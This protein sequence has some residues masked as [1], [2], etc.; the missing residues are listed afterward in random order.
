MKK[1]EFIFG[2]NPVLEVLRSKK[3]KCH[4]IFISDS[5]KQNA[6][7]E[8]YNLSKSFGVKISNVDKQKIS[9]IAHDPKHQGVAARVDGYPF[10]SVQEILG[11]PSEGQGN[12]IIILDGI[13]DPHNLGAIIRTAH[14]LGADGII[15]P[16]D[17]ACDITATVVKSSAGAT[18]YLKIAQVVNLAREID[19]LKDSGLWVGGA[20]GEGAD[21]L[22]S[23]DFTNE[24]TV[25]VIGSEG[26]GLRQLIRK[27]CDFL[28]KIPMKGSIDSFNASVAAAL[29]MGEV[30][31]Q[32]RK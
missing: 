31:R 16:K 32:R 24:N 15:I 13:S 26:T 6:L 8:I 21:D 3:R 5:K 22:Y 27:K 23:H 14:L 2:I 17:N 1:N 10:S 29:I 18:E 9:E 30:A 11:S 4:E 7:Q 20:A 19:T 28:L 25:L 12:F